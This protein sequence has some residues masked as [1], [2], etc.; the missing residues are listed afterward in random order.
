[1]APGLASAWTA[2]ALW[3]TLA[4]LTVRLAGVPPLLLAGCALT[5]GG[6]VGLPRRR[7]W[8][9]AP[10]VLAL[11]VYG[12]FAYHFVFFKALRL[13]PPVEANLV[14]DL[15]P[16]L[17]VLLSPL[18]DPA[19][20]LTGRH[21]AAGL[22]GFTGAAL[23]VG[24]AQASFAPEHAAGYAF[25]LAA[26]LIWSTY[27]LASSRLTA[28][29]TGAVGLYSLVSGL[30]A[31]LCHALLEPRH[32]WSLGEVPLVLAMGVGPMGFAFYAWDDA[33][34]RGDPRVVGVLSYFIPLAS[35]LLLAAFAGGRLG[36]GVWGAM[37]LIVGGGLLGA[38]VDLFP[39]LSENRA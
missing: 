32:A 39:R 11:G 20:R 17:I 29:P 9:V 26:A 27:S 24:G 34:K 6:L 30:L 5:I 1:M 22:M 37:A 28:V 23:L 35:T 14:N 31:L 3:S 36:P 33:M 13:A 15:W 2:I 19:R 25:A 38:G 10:R 12:L 21:A 18:F 4:T 7:D 16:L 8:R